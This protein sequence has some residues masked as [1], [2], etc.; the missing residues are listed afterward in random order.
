MSNDLQKAITKEQLAELHAVIAAQP[1]QLD[2]PVKHY[3]VSAIPG[4]PQG[5]V[6]AREILIPKGAVVVGKIHKFEQLN[7]MSKGDMT[8]A[9]EEGVM[10][11]QA[12]FTIVSP[13]GVKRAAYAH[14]D[15]VWTTIHGTDE[16]DVDV[17]ESMFVVDTYDKYLEFV[18]TQM[19]EEK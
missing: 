5:G 18:E 2:I 1:D 16:Q 15:T 7:I 14:E 12:P 10:R 3:H 11:V 8:L 9:T 6:Y 19:I 13:S 17:I 4:T